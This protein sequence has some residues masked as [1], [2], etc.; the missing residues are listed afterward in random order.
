MLT[1]KQFS[2][3]ITIVEEGSFT[4]ASEK[5]FIA[6]SALSRQIKNLEE[7][8]GFL[9]FDRSEKKIQLTRA[10]AALYQSLKKNIADLQHSIEIAQAISQ[11]AGRNLYMTHSSSV[12][13]NK[14]KLDLFNQLCKS[15][16]INIEINT[17][18]SESQIDA[19]LS[20]QSDIGLIRPPIYHHLEDVNHTT[21]YTDTLYVAVPLMDEYFKQKTHINISELKDCTFVSTPHAQR[22]G[23]SYLIANLCLT[24]G[25]IQK[26][27]P[28]SSRKISQLDLVA[29]GLGI[30]IVPSEFSE[31]LPKNVKLVPINNINI[32][33]EV[34]MIW[35][36]N[37]D[38]IIEK[39]VQ[40]MQNFFINI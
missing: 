9:V 4:S 26:K 33:T 34:R 16:K 18:S 29:Y 10:G 27:S 37:S 11:G 3:L 15:F 24:H 39:C 1:F 35:K 19:I 38:P 2:Y 31:I 6:Q 13:L 12:I 23:L 40:F 14:K 20:G 36:K 5:L 21:L 17:L 8:L 32:D 30:C 25:F 22:G 7:E 28:I